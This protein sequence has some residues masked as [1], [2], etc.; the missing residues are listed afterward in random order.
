MSTN[1]KAFTLVELLVVIA[2]IGILVALLLPAI[3]AARAAAWR[4]SCQNNIRQLGLAVHNYSDTKKVLPSSNRPPGITN[5]PRISSLTLLLPF[6]EE[7]ALFGQ[8]DQTKNW[9]DATTNAAG[10]TNKAVVNHRIS[11]LQC[12][13][14]PD[15]Q[16]LDADPQLSPWTNDV[17]AATDYSPT[18]YVDQ[19]LKAAGLVEE[20]ATGVPPTL[21]N[22]PG[23]GML[24][25][26][27][28]ST[29]K[30]VTDGTSK[31]IMYA[32][33]AG[34]PDLYRKGQQVGDL[35]SSK[36]NGGGWCRPAS[37]ISIDGMSGDGSTDVGTCALN[38]ANGV[39]M[40]SSFPHPYYVSVGTGEPY[41]FHPGGANFAMGDG[42]VRWINDNIDIREFAKLVTR[43]GSE[44]SLGDQ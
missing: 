27:I 18:I 3:Q 44:S 14:T 41:S 1:R 19:R 25:Y 36:V 17:G 33:C 31:T 16:R 39:E 11:I 23:L 38:C 42:S 28:V 30:E 26:N 8:Y 32:E 9:S 21:G 13:S 43:R 4:A 20:A 7:T 12:P 10:T 22:D 29:L 15:P 5:A 24:G 6:F 35:P 2:I 37:D 34:R 40:G